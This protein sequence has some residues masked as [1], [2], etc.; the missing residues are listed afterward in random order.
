MKADDLYASIGYGKTT[1]R[2]VLS[3]LVGPDALQ[4]KPTGGITEH[5]GARRASTPLA[6]SSAFAAATSSTWM[7]GWAFFCGANSPPHPGRLPD[8]EARVA[9][10][11]LVL[12]L[13]VRAQA[14]RVDVE[15]ARAVAV[16]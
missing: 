13:L 12:A 2:A 1:A 7:A 5:H 11:E 8:R 9:D 15:R 4:E 6:S 14:E 10:P 3:R 16:G